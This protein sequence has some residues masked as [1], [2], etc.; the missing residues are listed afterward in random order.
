MVAFLMC[1]MQRMAVV[2]VD[3]VPN[4]GSAA[5]GSVLQ[6]TTLL[7]FDCLFVLR[8]A[9]DGSGGDVD[10]G[11]GQRFLHPGRDVP[12]L[13]HPQHPL[14]GRKSCRTFCTRI[15]LRSLSQLDR[16]RDSRGSRGWLRCVTEGKRLLESDEAIAILG[17]ARGKATRENLDVGFPQEAVATWGRVGGHVRT[18]WER[19]VPGKHHQSLERLMSGL[20]LFFF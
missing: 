18:T 3:C 12:G 5:Y 1:R 11:G 17:S 13:P 10:S 4:V 6:Y 14:S 16:G 20:F 19:E 8:D 15:R 2:I 7:F 9:A